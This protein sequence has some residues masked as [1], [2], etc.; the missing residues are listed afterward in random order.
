MEENWN[1]L[2]CEEPGATSV[3]AAKVLTT[4]LG[5]TSEVRRSSICNHEILLLV[6]PRPDG[7]YLAAQPGHR[8]R[9]WRGRIGY[10]RDQWLYHCRAPLR[11]CAI[12]A[13]TGGPDRG[14]TELRDHDGR[15][16]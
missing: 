15:E 16:W 2:V 6:L 4:V 11:R 10:N 7:L 9:H 5:S 8:H 1:S 14:G 13:A 3:F 12:D